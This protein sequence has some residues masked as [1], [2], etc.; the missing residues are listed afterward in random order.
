MG[1]LPKSYPK[2]QRGSAVRMVLDR[3]D[4]Y[5]SLYVACEAIGKKQ[6]RFFVRHR[7]S[8]RGNS[9]LAKQIANRSDGKRKA[10]SF[11]PVLEGDSTLLRDGRDRRINMISA[12]T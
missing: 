9:T 1:P 5:P 2:D 10:N 3:L 8:M 6:M 11:G 7:L 4:D 12:K